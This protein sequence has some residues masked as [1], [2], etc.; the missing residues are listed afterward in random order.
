MVRKR[1][2]EDLE[3]KHVRTLRK[4]V[5]QA[6]SHHPDDAVAVAAEVE[7]LARRI[8]LSRANELIDLHNRYYPCEA[9]LPMDPPTGRYL[10]SGEPWVP[11]AHMTFG[12]LLEKLNQ[13]VFEDD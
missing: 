8:D 6:R 7:E 9:N 3:E 2:I 12:T 4:L 10:E 5:E 11:L 1:A 13:A